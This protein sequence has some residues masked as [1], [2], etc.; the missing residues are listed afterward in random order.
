[1]PQSFRTLTTK[2]WHVTKKWLQ[3]KHTPPFWKMYHC[4]LHEPEHNSINFGE[5]KNQREYFI[6]LL[7]WWHKM[8]YLSYLSKCT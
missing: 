6:D 1:L 3:F 5:I 4:V 2:N 8:I 7:N